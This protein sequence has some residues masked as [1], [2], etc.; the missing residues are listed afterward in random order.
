MAIYAIGD[1]QGCFPALE[2][3]LK[4]IQFT[5]ARDQLWFA[6]DLVSRGTHSLETLRFVHGLGAQ[7]QCILGNHDISLIAAYYGLLQPHKTL[8]PLLD[9][10]D[11]DTLISWLR[12]QPLMHT[13]DELNTVMVHA[14]ISP[15]WG[16]SHAQLYAREIETEL[17]SSSPEQWLT[18]VYGNKPKDWH[19]THP[20]LDRHRYILNSF[21]RMRYLN[22]DGSLEF[23]QKLHP[24][25]IARTHPTLSP[26]FRYQHAMPL[27][28]RV[29]FGHWS[30]LGYHQTD[31]IIA[32]DTGCVW[33]GQLTAVRLD[34]PTP[35]PIHIECS[36][37]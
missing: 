2:Q 17:R 35:Q 31:K 4:R 16:I 10:H 25:V 21:T 37:V 36:N 23:K 22:Q 15:R 24:E 34:T 1:L 29:V 33:G 30:T 6:G 14:G 27:S 3:L 32:L 7:A 20:R 9:A 8:T 11:A 26:W 13:D 12:Q 18:A 19:D 5:P 28:H